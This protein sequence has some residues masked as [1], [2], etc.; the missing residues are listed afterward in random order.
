MTG[1]SFVAGAV[2]LLVGCGAVTVTQGALADDSFLKPNTLVISS[3]TYEKTGAVATLNPLG[4][5][6]QLPGPSVPA[7]DDNY[8]TVWN[9][10]SVDA[11]FG[12]TSPITLTDIEPH[13]GHVFGSLQVPRNQVVTSFSSK[14]ELALSF[15]RDASGAHLVFQGYAGPAEGSPGVGALDVSNADAVAGQDPTNPVTAYFGNR[16]FFHRTIVALDGRNQFSYT[17]TENYGG[18]NGRAALLGSNGLYY[19]VGNSNAGNAGTF[20]DPTCTNPALTTKKRNCTSPDV[21]ET[22]GVE[23][24]KPINARVASVAPA[25]PVLAGGSGSAEVNPLLQFFLDNGGDDKAGKDDNFRGI[26]EY[27]GALYFTKGS[28]SNGVQTVYT[29]TTG[30]QYAATYMPIPDVGPSAGDVLPTVANAGSVAVQILNGFPTDSSRVTG[31]DYAPFAL[32]FANPTTLYVTDEG[33]NDAADAAVHAGLQKWV[34][35]TTTGSW[36]LQYTLQ[37]GLIGQ[38][39]GPLAGS[40]GTW[41]QVTTIG[42]RNLAGRVNGDGTV[43]LWAVTS[44]NS[45]AADTGADP[46]QVVQIT[47]VI[48]AT[49]AGAGETFTTVA[50]PTYGTVY[51]GVAFVTS[52]GS[53]SRGRMPCP[54]HSRIGQYRSACSLHSEG[55]PPSYTR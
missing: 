15:T 44:T 14:S 35:D 42:L 39:Y 11:N 26:T 13:S 20:G 51:R 43:T 5:T 19:T 38:S 3:T 21:T 7:S 36:L 8:V 34:L 28:G 6:A 9:N 48:S 22:T 2:A 32:F 25:I 1:R 46:N 50:G 33:T 17:P 4:V 29:V 23:V 37:A 18:D 41:P 10:D 52:P 24:V 55:H 12:V 53:G 49:A 47:D 54:V 30:P 40:D 31:G 27:N 16:H 45:T